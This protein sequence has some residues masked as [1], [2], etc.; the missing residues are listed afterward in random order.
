MDQLISAGAQPGLRRPT[1]ICAGGSVILTS[2]VGASYLW[3][4]GSVTPSI[5][6]TESGSYQVT[7][8]DAEGCSA[9]SPLVEVVV[10]PALRMRLHVSVSPIA[11]CGGTAI[12][13]AEGRGGTPPYC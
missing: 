6:I 9:T 5:R 3:S 2:S 8:T 11:G 4:D 1:S 12:A 7:V 10:L 13:T